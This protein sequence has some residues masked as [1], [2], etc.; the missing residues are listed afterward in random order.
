MLRHA[1]LPQR[2]EAESKSLPEKMKEVTAELAELTRKVGVEGGLSDRAGG[3]E[4]GCK[5]GQAELSTQ[6]DTVEVQ[7][8]L[9]KAWS[10]AALVCAGTVGWVAAAS[11]AAS[12]G[13]MQSAG[14]PASAPAK[15]SI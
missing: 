1:A 15:E 9:G 7:A 3:A 11:V 4:L 8:Q 5:A 6:A 13:C 14:L 2:L 10:K 12:H